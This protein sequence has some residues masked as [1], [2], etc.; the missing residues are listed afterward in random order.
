MRTEEGGGFRTAGE[1]TAKKEGE[2]D[3]NQEL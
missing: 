1:K 2:G 3:I